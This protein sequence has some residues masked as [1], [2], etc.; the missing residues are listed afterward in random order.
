MRRWL[1]RMTGFA[2]LI[3]FWVPL[4]FASQ[5]WQPLAEKINKSERDPRQY[6]AITLTNGMTVLLVSDAKAPKSLAA[7]ALPVGSLE[8]PDSQLGLAHYLE[9]MVLMG[10]KRYP[11]PESFAEFLKKHGGSHNASTASYRT[12]YYLEVENNA[13]DSAVDR[14][15]DAIAEPIL[16][17]DNADRERNAVNAELTMARSRDVMRMA[18]VG[19]ETLNPAHPSAR[20]SGGNLETLKDKPG[21]KLHDELT[22]FYQR[23]YSANLMVGVLYGNQSLPDLAALAAKTFGRIPNR[24]AKVPPITVPAVTPE[25]QGI[26]IH[27]VPAQP[28][29]Q[30][31]V[32][33]R[34][35]NN[36]AEFRSKTDTFI[37]YLIGNRSKN[38][39]SDWLQ[40]QGLADAISAGADP[41]VDRNGGVFVISVSLTDKGLA[42][43]DRVVAAIFSYLQMLRTEGVKQSYFDEIARVLNLGFRYPAIT[44]NMNYIEWLVDTM[45]RVPVQHTLDASYLADR[46]DPKAISQRLAQ[47]TPQ[48]ARIWFIS[49]NE[50]HNKTAY[51]VDA[52]YQVEKI[53]SER[54][55]KWQRLG[56]GITLS[57]PVP[58]PYIPD[59][60]NLNKSSRELSK[61]E[62]VVNQPGLRVLYMPSRYFSDEPKADVKVAF[63]NAKTLDSARNQVLFSLMDYLAGISLDQL[64]YQASVGGLN[65]STSSNNGLMFSANG[66]TQRLPQLLTSLI[67]GY[68]SFTSTEEQFEQAKSWYLEQLDAAEK[69]KAYELAIQPV[70]GLSPV[71]YSERSERREVLKTLTLK[72]V[73]AY[74]DSLIVGATPELLVVGNMSK[75]QVESLASSLKHSVGCTGVDW[76]HGENVVIAKNQFA[77]LQRPGSSTDSALAAVYVPIG[78]D[79]ITSMAYS[80]LLG[81]IIQPWFYSQLRTQEQLGYAVFAFAEPVGR[82]WGIAFLLQSNSKQPAYLYQRYQDFYQNT[83]KRLREISDSDFT[84]YKQA[85]INQLK[86][87]PQTLREEAGRFSNDFDRGNFAFDT[88]EKLIAQVEALTPSKL[89][90]YFHHA[91]IQ[92][93]G[94]AVLSQ[95]S[96]NNQEKADFATPG[97]GWVTYPNASS[98]QKTLPRE[99]AMP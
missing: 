25:Q 51:F 12:A 36:S 86:Q 15:A 46:Y 61:P 33:F 48:N 40:Q 49:P 91:V 99:V 72:D 54:F 3:M 10:S 41:M 88:R 94:L 85:M 82:Q 1:A 47:M 8:N 89:A 7:L 58:N 55:D 70:R 84:Q 14:L 69:G 90:D 31:K 26:I 66:F 16:D 38:T 19:S 71:P 39:L 80:S 43:R 87:R 24:D 21:S 37:S 28:T 59:D 35:D 53:T 92:P 75:Q 4:S 93:Q 62:I 22:G 13:F 68:S 34:I 45:L 29:K 98:L 77:N 67:E 11:E 81:Q 30:L 76:W 60:F 73:L 83:E 56:Q 95:V 44:R 74:R 5:G 20:F 27:Y 97:E 42:E 9:H 18:Q 2:L 79:E 65:F 96:G 78:Y 63:R 32:E 23:Y 50:P 64:G 57:L 6:Q 52:L 17:P